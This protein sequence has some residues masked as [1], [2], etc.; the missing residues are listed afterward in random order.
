MKQHNILQ[1]TVVALLAIM[2]TVAMQAQ[3]LN[4]SYF[5]QD[6]KYRHQ[7]NPAF[8]NDQG[9]C[10]IPVLGNLDIKLQGNM[11]MSDF[12][13]ENPNWGKPG[14]KRTVTFMHPSISYDD[15]MSGFGDDGLKMLLDMRL[16]LISL[17]FKGFGGYNTIEVNDRTSLGI[18]LPRDLLEFAKNVHNDS[19]S[20][21]D[22][23]LR[24]QN[25]A[26]IAF[27]H[28][29]DINE[30][31]RVGAKLKVLLGIG[32]ADLAMDGMSANLTGDTWTLQGKARADISLK[33]VQLKMK[34][35]EYKSRYVT[36]AN[37][38]PKLDA[39]GEK[40]PQKY[41]KVD[42]IDVDGAG[43]GGF[44][45]GVDL[46]GVYKLN[47]D[48]TL[49]AA[50]TDLGFINWSNNVV[51]ETDGTPFQFDGFKDVAIKSDYAGENGTFKDKGKSYGDQLSDFMNLQDKG[52]EGGRTTMLSATVSVGAEYTLPMYRKL[53][54]GL[55]LQ[56]HFAG[57]NFSWNEGRLSANWT[58]LRWLNGG[59]NFGL[60]SYTA[61]M[62]WII[63]IHPKAV[64]FF[65][66][67]DHVV[68][69]TNKD[70]IPVNDAN[71]SF[72][73]GMNVAWGGAKKTRRAAD[74]LD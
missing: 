60:T 63:N 72:A 10:A 64:N 15:A 27:G 19:Y 7:L 70:M 74:T 35:D 2:A 58:P 31:L 55:L 42:D 61:S 44:G 9:Y 36:D 20:F 4:S 8:G 51:A 50:I 41:Q 5:T 24:V 48:I 26:E 56:R 40:I 22:L 71:F 23:S 13:F 16:T 17:G 30:K 39:N 37:G 52:D 14:E 29:R 12:L 59:V 33:G 25:F 43:L 11:G 1:K 47:D 53:S 34:E 45:L 69:K 18:S 6:F 57:E 68:G 32:R 65:I 73:L 49:S 21:D 62:G 38:N 67:M 54:A 28:S 46:G 3:D 66:G